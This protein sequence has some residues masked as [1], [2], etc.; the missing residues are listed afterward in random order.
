MQ[1]L[2]RELPQTHTSFEGSHYAG[3]GEGLEAVPACPSLDADM[4]PVPL[5]LV[6]NSTADSHTATCTT[7]AAHR[8]Q[9]FWL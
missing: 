6:M 3:V 2:G 9:R 7:W 1:I 5:S 8:S 4:Q